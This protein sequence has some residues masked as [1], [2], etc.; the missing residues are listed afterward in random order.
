VCSSD[1]KF[2]AKHSTHFVTSMNH[3]ARSV[4]ISIFLAGAA[5][6]APFLA[7]G[8]GAELFATGALAVRADDNIFLAANA[9]SDVI[10]DIN[11]GVELTFGKNAQLS[12]ALT[13]VDSFSRYSSNTSLNTNLFSA[14]FRSGFDDG[15]LK[16]TFNAGY[17]ET[18]QN[19]VDVR[20]TGPIGAL[21]RRNAY[22]AGAN[23]EA[24]VSQITS[25]AA[26]ISFSHTDYRRAGYGDSD[27]YTIPVDFFYKM[28]PKVDLS[29]GYRYR[30]YQ[31]AV[32]QDSTD[33]FFNVG[34]RGEFTPKLTG[35]FAV[36]LTKRHLARSDDT[37][38]LGLDASLS[39]E[40]SPKTSLQI[41]SSSSPD[42][43]PQGAQQ[44]N[45]SIGGSVT[46]NISE[47][48]SVNGGISWRAINY[49]AA[50]G[51]PGHVDDYVEG[52]LGATYIVNAYVRV[53]GAYAYRNNISK[54]ASSEFTNNVFSLATSFRY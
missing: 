51:S 10:F 37:S 31:T 45:F 5:Q 30:N 34:A 44:K 27:D 20:A 7:I 17:R 54:T 36:G 43:S 41:N 39:Y 8:D 26:G 23:A 22:T 3:L 24:E 35:H 47:Q 42:T 19:T 48:W 29:A 21:I 50:T 28:T 1:L 14:D 12:G 32:G 46:S 2:L 52:Q 40:I 16:M 18:N 6:A 53:V 38:M 4:F 15:K 11:P 49:L 9:E 13:M 33:Q 25:I